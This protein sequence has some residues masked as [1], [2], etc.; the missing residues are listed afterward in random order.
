MIPSICALAAAARLASGACDCGYSIQRSEGEGVIVFM[1]RLE[2]EFGQL[3]NI[4]QSHEWVAQEFTVSAED[5]R[6]NYS[7]DFEPANI[8][9]QATHP[10]DHPGQ[11]Q[12]GVE[13]RYFNDTQEIDIEFLSQEFDRDRIIY[14]V[15]LVVQS[16]ASLEAGYDASKTRNFKRVDLDFDPTESFHEYRFDYFLGHVLFYADGKML[17]QMEGSDMPTSGGHLI[18]QHWSNGNPLWSGGPPTKDATVTVNYV[19]A[20]FNSSDHD[21]QSYLQGRCGQ[22]SKRVSYNMPTEPFLDILLTNHTDSKSLFAHVTGRD[23]QG[24]VMLLADGETLYRPESPSEILQPVG[25]DVAILIGEPGAQ[26]RVRIPHIFGGRIWFC[27]ENPLTFL[28]NPGPAVVE[29]SVMNPTD[30]N[31]HADWGFCEFTYN[32]D[33]LY[34]NVSYVDFVSLPIGLELENEAGKVTH[35]PGLPKDGLDQVC[36]GLK[37][38][39]ESDGAGWEKLVVKSDSGSNL[40]A[41]SINAA[42]ELH[43]G[44]LENYF[45]PEIDAAWKRYEEEDVEINTQAEWGDVRGRVHHGKLV[46]KNVGKDKLTFSFSKPS[47]R[48]IVS[49]S[50]GPFAGGPDVTPAQLNV[51][52]RLAAALNRTTLS[53]NCRQ[54]EGEKVEEYYCRGKGEGRTNHY[55]RICH[56]V[57]LEG[58]GYAF[59]YDDV[60]ASEGVDQSGFLN[61]GRPKLLTIHVGG[62]E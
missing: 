49:C 36:E 39:G 13:L 60:G 51:G 11:S 56:E 42:A 34:V 40:R 58:K 14:P 19:K 61:D 41:L 7:K 31:F 5:G 55:S 28:L 46:F 32:N 27:K 54:P 3:Q 37:R 9:I 6:G 45:A 17:A 38:Q 43:P 12:G 44:L 26:K 53:G 24:V 22:S 33:Q 15:N 10:Q 25:A 18:L 1:D 8:A 29:P 16:K 48:D 30:P 57:T 4:S 20:Y 23:E 35:V 47:T 59:P 21:R 50:S 62:R 2:T 52:A